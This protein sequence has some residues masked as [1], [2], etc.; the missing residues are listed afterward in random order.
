MEGRGVGALRGGGGGRGGAAG[1]NLPRGPVA[2][3]K[4]KN[5]KEWRIERHGG[6]WGAVKPGLVSGFR[7]LAR[8]VGSEPHGNRRVLRGTSGENGAE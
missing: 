5:R 2:G 3:K 4:R 6:S 8:S 1:G 7:T